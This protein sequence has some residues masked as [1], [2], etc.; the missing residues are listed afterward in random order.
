MTAEETA[1]GPVL[2]NSIHQVSR[3]QRETFD[4]ALGDVLIQLLIYVHMPLNARPL[5]QLGLL[6]EALLCSG[7]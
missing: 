1:G 2:K 5:G 7:R 4:L 3:T 6:S